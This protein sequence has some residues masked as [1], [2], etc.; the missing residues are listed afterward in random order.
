[1]TTKNLYEKFEGK[2]LVE[3]PQV[4]YLSGDL[5]KQVHEEISSKYIYFSV[6]TNNITYDKKSD[7]VK[8][9]KPFYVVAVN[10]VLR[11]NALHTATPAEYE[12]ILAA[13]ARNKKLGL[14]LRGTYEDSALVL[15]TQSDLN[16]YL[17]KHLL[18]QLK[19]RNPKMKM[20]VMIPLTGFDLEPILIGYNF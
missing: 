9:S 4:N 13:N 7:L 8:G 10:E 2:K 3:I 19:K 17:A 15:R 1:M 5:G 6:V 20:P 16:E 11:E 18:S 12:M 14:D